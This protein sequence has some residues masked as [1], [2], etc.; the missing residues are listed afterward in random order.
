MLRDDKDVILA[1]R[2]ARA[3]RHS[4]MR[5]RRRRRPTHSRLSARMGCIKLSIRDVGFGVANRRRDRSSMRFLGKPSR[6]QVG[7][8]PGQ[9]RPPLYLDSERFVCSGTDCWG[10]VDGGRKSNES[11]QVVG[12]RAKFK[13]FRGWTDSHRKKKKPGI[14]RWDQAPGTEAKKGLLPKGVVDKQRPNKQ[15][16][17]SVD[18]LLLV[19]LGIVFCAKGRA[20]EA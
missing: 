4:A 18:A 8:T 5:R 13:N 10:S 19:K 2:Q 11:S 12:A 3:L 17:E 16:Q 15:R 7:L 1:R 9:W 14:R 6:Q 20:A